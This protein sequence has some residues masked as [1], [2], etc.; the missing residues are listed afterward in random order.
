MAQAYDGFDWDA[1]N[2]EKCRKHGVL[3]AE[4]EGVFAM[5]P[6]V[7]PDLAHSQEEARF[8]A[9]GRSLAGRHVFI[10]FTVRGRDGGRYVRP[11]SARFMHQKEIENLEEAN[12]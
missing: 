11:I 2:R 8:L 7:R 6:A 3:L 1:G 4:V 10:V 12:S 5:Q 9:I